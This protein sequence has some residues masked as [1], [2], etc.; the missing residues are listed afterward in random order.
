VP[1]FNRC[2]IFETTE[3]SWHGFDQISIPVEHAGL[4]RKSVAL[5]FYSKDRP[6]EEVAGKH[7]THYVNRQLPDYF[8]DGYVLNSLDVG[9]LRE[10]IVYRDHQL[11]RL[12]AENASLLQAQE[13]GFGG[14]LLYS[15][16]RLYVRYRR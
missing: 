1:I 14:N 13:R 12:Y 10:M 5:Y 7:T 11:Q 2:V 9:M 8:I 15:L 3:H 16:K 4:S 6:S